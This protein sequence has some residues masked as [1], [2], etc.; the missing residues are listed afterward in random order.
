MPLPD[1]P[2]IDGL[3][4]RGREARNLEYK[5]S[6]PW[7]DLRLG[8]VKAALAFA[9]T[10]DGGYIVIGMEQLADDRYEPQGMTPEHLAGYTLDKVQT[11]V[12][13]YAAPFV[14]LDATPHKYG[15]KTFFVIAVDPF[16]D[17]P[18]ICTRDAE[19]VLRRA[20]IY[21]RSRRMVSSAPIDNPEDMRAL[22]DLATDRAVARLRARGILQSVAPSTPTDDD[23]FTEQERSIERER[24]V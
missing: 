18:V 23:R 4:A 17:V 2:D 3:I 14:S 19:V 9:N 16:E 24:E 7:D 11:E 1:G 20:A 21:T 15:G 5:R 13:R 8:I 6:A 22:I 12:N 10:R